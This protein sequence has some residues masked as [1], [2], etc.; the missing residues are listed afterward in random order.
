VNKVYQF[1]ARPLDSHWI[2]V[3]RILRNLTGT[4][5][6]G[7]HFQPASFDHPLSL[8]A[9]CDADWASD[10]DGRRSTSGAAIFLGPNLISW[11]SRKQQ[12]TTW[13]S[14]EAKYRSLA[15]TSTELPRISTLLTKLQISFT[16]PVFL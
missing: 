16:T 5:F 6:H 13:S 8:K 7:L 2:V 11:S 15:K 4:L 14:V 10:V 1:I 3:K 9:S 12:A